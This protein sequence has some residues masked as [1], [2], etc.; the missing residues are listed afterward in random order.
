L[1]LDNVW[2]EPAASTPRSVGWVAV[3]RRRRRTAPDREVEVTEVVSEFRMGVDIR[4]AGYP[5]CPRW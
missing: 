5:R 1:F 3:R 4:A 2:L